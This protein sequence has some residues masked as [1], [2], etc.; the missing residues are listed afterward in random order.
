MS[1]ELTEK[2]FITF[3]NSFLIFRKCYIRNGHKSYLTVYIYNKCDTATRWQQI[4][5]IWQVIDSHY[6][7]PLCFLKGN[8]LLLVKEVLR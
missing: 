7:L 2:M 3:K 8:F 1:P 4:T 5:V 6:Q